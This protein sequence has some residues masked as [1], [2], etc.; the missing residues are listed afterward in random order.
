M[1]TFQPLTYVKNIYNQCTKGHQ[2]FRTDNFEG[3]WR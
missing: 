3:Y 1:A 2:P